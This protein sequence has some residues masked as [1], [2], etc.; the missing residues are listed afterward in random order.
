MYRR[1]DHRHEPPGTVCADADGCKLTWTSPDVA[2]YFAS[3]GW[4]VMFPQR[5]GRGQSDGLY[6]EGLAAD[7]TK[8]YACEPQRAIAGFDRAVADLDVVMAHVLARPDVDTRRLLIGGT[9]RG[10]ILA[11]AYAGMHPEMFVGVLNFVGGWLGKGCT[12]AKTVNPV[13]LQRGVSFKQPMLWIYGDHDPYYKLAHSRAN[14]DAFKSAGG[15]A[16]FLEFQPATGR[17]GHMLLNEPSIWTQA[18]DT[19]LAKVDRR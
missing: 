9:S 11:V 17:D 18:M 3:K 5:R 16:E 10:G 4:Q 19:Y 13:L 8:G 6:D 7:R 14:Y 2:R 1:A 15:Q 12:S